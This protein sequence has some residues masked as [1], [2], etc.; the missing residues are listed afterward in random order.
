MNLRHGMIL[1][2]VLIVIAILSLGALSF[3]QL[4]ITE[5]EAVEISVR[6]M[7]TRA[8]AESGIEAARALVA[9]DAESRLE[10][11]GTYDNTGRFRGV[12]VIDR[13]EPHDRGRF[14]LISPSP[15]DGSVGTG[16][17]FGLDDESNRLNLNALLLAEK[18]VAG[19]GRQLLMGLPGMTEEIADAILDWMDPDDETREYGAEADAYASFDPPYAPKNGPLHSIEELLL[20]QGVTPQLLFGSDVN[21]NGMVDPGEPTPESLGN[22]PSDGSMNCG[23]AA[24]LTLYSLESNLQADGS[25]RIN[26]NQDDLTKLNEALTSVLGQQ[27]ATFIVACR[28]F[29]L[30]AAAS[31]PSAGASGSTSGTN[32]SANSRG[33]SA[34][35]AAGGAAA[36]GGATGTLDL[37]QTPKYKF[38]TVLDLIGAKVQAKFQG[39]NQ[40]TTLESPFANSPVAMSSYLPKMMDCLTINASK[41]IPGRINVN[42]ASRTVLAGVPGMTS[43]ILEQILSA[44]TPDPV[45][46][47]ASRRYE[48]WLLQEG[49]VTLAQMKQMMPF[50]CGGGSVFRAQSVGYFDQGGPCSRIE[51]IIDATNSPPRVIFWRDMS[52]LGQ[53]YSLETLGMESVLE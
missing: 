42:Q 49:I 25:E 7:Q 9:Q 31:D 29:G 30:Q 13:P 20:V 46:A 51:A 45:Q 19:S 36:S 8:L 24:Y 33:T 16:L 17:R 38:T 35:N 23:W 1:V 28:L 22:D 32:A 5:R 40:A 43:E 41:V 21:R 18:A 6:G 11:G 50:L 44:R 34:G 27:P 2:V 4:M 37:T 47:D 3:A 26:I 12:V 53:G 10:A 15:P 52:H 14:T 48:T 39:Q